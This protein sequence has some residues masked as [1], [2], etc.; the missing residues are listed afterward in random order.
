MLRLFRIQYQPLKEVSFFLSILEETPITQQYKIFSFSLGEGMDEGA[1]V[2]GLADD[3]KA[4][5]ILISSWNTSKGTAG[6]PDE[7]CSTVVSPTP[8]PPT[9]YYYYNYYHSHCHDH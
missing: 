8:P 6:T 9:H 3:L 2:D 7:Y 1:L 5:L 4:A